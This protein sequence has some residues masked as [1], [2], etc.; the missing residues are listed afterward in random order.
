MEGGGKWCFSWQDGNDA[1][2][3]EGVDAVRRRGERR[4]KEKD[5]Q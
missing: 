2:H 3:E 5:E 1:N 4:G